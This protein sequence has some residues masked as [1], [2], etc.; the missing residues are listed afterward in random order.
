MKIESRWW[1]KVRE[2]ATTTTGLAGLSCN[3]GG[4]KTTSLPMRS[5]NWDKRMKS[6]RQKKKGKRSHYGGLMLKKFPVQRKKTQKMELKIRVLMEFLTG[7]FV[8]FA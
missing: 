8:G 3:S 4:W 2:E 6:N 1:M 5:G 7:V